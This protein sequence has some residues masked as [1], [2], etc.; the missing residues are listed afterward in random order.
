MSRTLFATAACALLMIP[1]AARTHAEVAAAPAAPATSAPGT[2]A[3]SSKLYRTT[4]PN[5]MKV[6][7]RQESGAPLVAVDVFITVGSGMETAQ[8]AGIGSFVARALLASTVA[9]SSETIT[10]EIA[11]LGGSVDVSRQPDWTRISALA[12]SDR[13]S[14]MMSLITD[15]LKNATFDPDIVE[16][17][18]A[19]MLSDI[20]DSDAGLFTVT[21]NGV[22]SRL[23]ANSGY[24][25]PAVGT[26]R[27]IQRIT[28]RQ[29]QQ[30]YLRYYIPQNMTV[31]IV[32]NIK[33]EDAVSEIARDMADYE[34][35]V[36]GARRVPA[37][38]VELPSL[39]GDPAPFH[40]TM[41]DLT[42]NC[43]MAGFRAPSMSNPDYFALQVANALLGGMKTSRMF[44]NLREKQ[45]LAYDLG[46]FYSPQ[47]Y[48]G[49]LTAYIFTAAS[50]PS[51]TPPKG[52]PVADVQKLLLDQI[53]DLQ[54]KPAT[55]A[56]ISRAKHYLI[57]TQKIKHERIED[58]AE[59]LGLAEISSN[60]TG[61]LDEAFTDRINAVTA[62]DVQRVANKYFMHPAIAI[63]EP[64]SK[65]DGVVQR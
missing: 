10:G 5:G 24:A 50:A 14:V 22:R 60:D 4:L 49:D 1:S 35:G 58:R 2:A 18:R 38:L 55:D 46:S 27:S 47:L 56:E 43:V 25:L 12:V 15:V 65:N 8:N 48:S 6:V 40:A 23:F 9:R 42:Q 61:N 59:L 53:T 57:G 36:R 21:Y 44:T 52:N 30:Y 31:S 45:G 13:Y 19:D 41:S 54:T 62:A 37:P 7:V 51:A 39:A 32:G 16:Q 64:D 28:R 63:V 29:L 34:P 17:R 26:V 11:D 20:N 3:P 33:P